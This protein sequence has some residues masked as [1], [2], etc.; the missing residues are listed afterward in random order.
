[1]GRGKHRDQLLTCGLDLIRLQGFAATGVQEIAD[2]SG[3]PKGSF[4]NYFKS[5]DAFTLEVLERYVD[6]SCEHIEDTLV[7]GR[8]SPLTR[9]KTLYDHWITDFGR[10]GYVGGCFAGKLSQE[11][12]EINPSFREALERSF[13]RTQACYAVC[14]REAKEVGEL[15]PDIDPDMLAAFVYNSWQGAMLRMKASGNADPLKQ[16]RH[17]VF[18]HLLHP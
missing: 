18:T 5:K 7:R 4:Y 15:S 1:M 10:K 3:V 8:G 11:L 9:L 6:M 14:L 12:A 13:Q 17:F 2:A 16:F